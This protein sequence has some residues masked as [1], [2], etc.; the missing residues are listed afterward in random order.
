MR[1]HLTLNGE[2]TAL[3]A[4]RYEFLTE[5]IRRHGLIGTKR[6]CESGDCG[7]CAVLLDG[8]EVP[9]CIVLAAQADGHQVDTIEGVGTFDAPHPIQEAFV[10]CT[11]IQCG[12]CTPGMVMATKALLEKTPEPTERDAREVLAGHL[13]RCTGYTK[14]IKAVLLAAERCKNAGGAQ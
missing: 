4:K 6:G 13:C 9:S 2:E 1:I 7:A 11:A 12:Y 8:V 5:V 3:E 10:D 14:P